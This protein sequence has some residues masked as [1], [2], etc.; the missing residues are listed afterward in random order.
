MNL[1]VPIF[2]RRLGENVVNIYFCMLNSSSKPNKLPVTLA[3]L[4]SVVVLFLNI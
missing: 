3:V 2:L 1:L 4:M